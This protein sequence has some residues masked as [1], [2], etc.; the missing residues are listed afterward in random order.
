MYYKEHK[1]QKD[2]LLITNL[3]LNDT[4]YQN[5]QG[6]DK[7]ELSKNDLFNL[8]D[9]NVLN[10][11]KQDF[12]KDHEFKECKIK[13]GVHLLK[14]IFIIPKNIAKIYKSAYKE[15][16]NKDLGAGYFTQLH[17][18]DKDYREN[19]NIIHHR[20][21]LTPSKMQKIDFEIAKGLDEWLDN[22]NVCCFNVYTKDYFNA[23]DKDM[24][25]SDNIKDDTN[26]TQAHI[27][28][29]YNNT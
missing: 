11:L 17:E 15:F 10:T 21:F 6:L 12:S 9:I 4:L 2:N 22:E 24:L 20:V 28:E 23:N 13:L 18:Y 5:E 14:L 29:N 3:Y 16:K 25:I 7:L 27:N 1:Y 19:E 8:N 26:T